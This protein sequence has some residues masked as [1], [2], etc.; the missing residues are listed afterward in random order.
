MKST[1]KKL[2]VA[3]SLVVILALEGTENYVYAQDTVASIENEDTIDL[4]RE[5]YSIIRADGTVEEYN[6]GARLS[7]AYPVLSPGES[8]V[9]Q[10]LPLKQGY[11]FYSVSWGQSS[12]FHISVSPNLI[13]NPIHEISLSNKQG[14]SG[15]FHY[16]KSGNIVFDVRNDSSSA[17]VL[18]AAMFNGK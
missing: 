9:W 10:G 17:R 16:G 13:S 4:L 1:L 7:I 15:S 2:V 14:Y 3:V 6:T 5:P 8:V 12:D 18:T 11:N